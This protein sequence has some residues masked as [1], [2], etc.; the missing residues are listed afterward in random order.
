MRLH[1][2]ISTIGAV[3]EPARFTNLQRK[4]VR[5]KYNLNQITSFNF[6]FKHSKLIYFQN[7]E[8]QTVPPP[9]ANFAGQVMQWII[10]DAYQQDFEVQQREK[11][12]EKKDKVVPNQKPEAKRKD[13]QAT[14]DISNRT[15]LAIKTLERMINQNTFDEI[16][17]GK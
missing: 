11:E 6:C 12:K 4:H 10:Y 14:A 2:V 8:T 7:L 3:N 16:A 1:I 9:R 13:L 17:Q 5:N 15:L